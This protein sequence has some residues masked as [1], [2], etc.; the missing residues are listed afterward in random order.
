MGVVFAF[1]ICS[2]VCIPFVA[3]AWAMK[4]RQCPSCHALIEPDPALV[5]AFIG[6]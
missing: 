4:P 2:A 5:R 1:I 3:L 6:E